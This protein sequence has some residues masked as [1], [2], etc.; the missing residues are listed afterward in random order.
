M[1]MD[2]SLIVQILREIKADP[3]QRISFRRY[4]ELALYHPHLG[5]YRRPLPKIGKEGDFYTS[6]KV[7]EVFGWSL[8]QAMARMV[9]TFPPDTPWLLIEAGAGDGTLAQQVIQSLAEQEQLPAAFYLIESSHYHRT[10]LEEL[11][12][13]CPVPLRLVNGVAEIPDGKPAIL[14]SNELLDAFPVH[15]VTSDQ[16]ALRELYVAQEGEKSA[17]TEVSGPLSR[18]ELESYFRELKWQ[19]PEGWTAEVPLDALEWLEEVGGWLEK[20]YLITD[21]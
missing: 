3:Q 6:P 1:A 11:A 17:L 19:L 8:A 20:G 9:D 21:R 4:M 15:R 12:G 16:G 2:R 18:P 5:Y 7:G 14:Y 13:R 10:Q